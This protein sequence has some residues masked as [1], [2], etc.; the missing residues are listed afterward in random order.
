MDG[1]IMRRDVISSRQP[2][3]LL[4]PNSKI[5]KRFWSQVR[6][7]HALGPRL[8]QVSLTFSFPE[9]LHFRS[10]FQEIFCLK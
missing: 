6:V 3:Q 7:N 1:R 9:I 2:L 4:L 8:Y 5:L 10:G